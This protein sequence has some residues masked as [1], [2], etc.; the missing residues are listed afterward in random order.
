MK[1][2]VYI[3]M[4]PT[5]FLSGCASATVFPAPVNT[6]TIFPSESSANTPPPTATESPTKIPAIPTATFAPLQVIP[7]SAHPL[8]L[9]KFNAGTEMKR[10]NVIGTG[11]PHAMAWSG[12]GKY[13]VVGTGLGLIVYDGQTYEKLNLIEIGRTVY[14]LSF[15]TD[16][17]VV[18]IA[19]ENETSIWNIETGAKILDM[20]SDIVHPYAIAYGRGNYIAVIGNFCKGCSSTSEIMILWNAETGEQ[21]FSQRGIWYWTQALAFSSDGRQLFFGGQDGL[22]VVNS[23]TGL[24]TKTINETP[25][26]IVMGKDDSKLLITGFDEPAQ[27]YD[28]ST[29]QSKPFPICGVYLVKA[30]EIGA[31]SQGEKIVIFSL[32]SAEKMQVVD[33]GENAALLREKFKLSLDNQYLAYVD[34]SIISIFD[35]QHNQIVK[36]LEFTNFE[37]VTTGII[38]LDGVE[39]YVGAVKNPPDQISLLDLQS[40]VVLRTFS[41]DCCEITGFAFAPDRKTAA[42]VSGRVLNL[43]DLSTQ[44]IVYEE[45][46]EKEYSGA[47]AF[48]P[49]GSKI[50]LTDFEDYDM[51]FN[52]ETRERKKLGR[53]SY[54]YDYFDPFAVDNFHFNEL[55]NLVVLEYKRNNEEYNPSFKD[56]VTSTKIVLPY[57]AVADPQFLESFALNLDGKYLAFG[58]ASGIYVWDTKTQKQLLYLDKHEWRGSDGWIGAIKSLIFNPQSDLLVSVGWDQTTRLWN[59]KAGNELRILNVCCSA[60]FTPDGR[61]LVTAGDGVMRV[62]GIP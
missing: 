3:F 58:N 40:G 26:N 5:L 54:V 14:V 59:I 2:L 46:L 6:I 48:S 47:I 21:I 29:Q 60:S 52:I 4:I 15:T 50:Y 24:L 28:Y 55:G 19:T 61:Y 20:E 17:R 39:K 34:G 11:T 12:N 37:Y 9:T 56:I 7:V 41:L 36:K 44:K 42:T 13:F 27:L 23:E 22:S 38:L 25:L 53:H 43:W 51:E 18:A 10:L 30:S 62:W 33:I 35:L 8:T 32:S 45:K 49:D 31:C 1:R 16:E 57:N